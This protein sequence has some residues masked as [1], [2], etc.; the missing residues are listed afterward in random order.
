MDPRTRRESDRMWSTLQLALDE[1]ER[2]NGGP[3]PAALAAT[4]RSHLGRMIDLGREIERQE[5]VDQRQ[6]AERAEEL[7]RRERERRQRLQA[8]LAEQRDPRRER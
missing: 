4:L 1:C 5:T 6:R 3:L 7:L 8:R 2:D